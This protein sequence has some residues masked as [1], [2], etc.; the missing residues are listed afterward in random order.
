M[1]YKGDEGNILLINKPYGL[2]SFD[3]VKKIKWK[4]GGKV[5]IGHA[6]TLDP[7]ATGLLILCTGK[8]TKKIPEIQIMEKEYEG[9][10]VLGASTVSF[11]L[12]SKPVPHKELPVITQDI[13]FEITKIFTGII[14][15]VPPLHSAVK[16][17]GKRAYKLARSGTEVE[18][19]EKEVQVYSFEIT[20]AEIPHIFFKIICSKGTYIRSLVNDYGAALGC[21][22]YL[23][24]LV[25][26]R[27]G[28]YKLSHAQT[29]EEFKEV[30]HEN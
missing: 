22:A 5:K 18:M 15:Q 25:R 23:A 30:S 1:E 20:K 10:M 7:L 19:K 12:E 13:I 9:M 2:S 14:R 11:D 17:K 21:G 4:F 26:T 24:S 28:N 16:I 8:A 3:V 29:I 27:V 6:G